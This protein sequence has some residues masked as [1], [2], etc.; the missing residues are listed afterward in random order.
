M[1]TATKPA[2]IVHRTSFTEKLAFPT[3]PDAATRKAL[4]LAG[5]RYN[6]LHWWRNQNQ[7][8]VIKPK[9][10]AALLTPINQPEAATA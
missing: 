4:V 8:G 10:L 3:K 9:Q 5:W 7:T 1:Q 2:P 6:G